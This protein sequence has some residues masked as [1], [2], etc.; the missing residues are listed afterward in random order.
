MGI[1]IATGP[2]LARPGGPT[3]PNGKIGRPSAGK[4]LVIGEPNISTKDDDK[5]K[6]REILLPRMVQLLE[7]AGKPMWCNR[8]R[9]EWNR[10][11][12]CLALVLEWMVYIVVGGTRALGI[13]RNGKDQVTA[14]EG[15]RPMEK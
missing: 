7:C 9:A 4:V 8:P 14:I 11:G 2:Q 6:V 5:V 12:H 1:L 10:G 15:F 13:Q 3:H